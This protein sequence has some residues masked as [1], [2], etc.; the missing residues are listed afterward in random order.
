MGDADVSRAPTALT[1]RRG[2]IRDSQ[3]YPRVWIRKKEDPLFSLLMFFPQA[4]PAP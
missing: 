4:D 3:N 1:F 2:S